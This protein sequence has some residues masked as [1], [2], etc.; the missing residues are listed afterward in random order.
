MGGVNGSIQGVESGE[1]H[2]CCTLRGKLN[3]AGLKI[4]GSLSNATEQYSGSYDWIPSEEVQ[5]IPI[6][7]MMANNDI[8]IEAIPSEYHDTS[9]ATITS[10]D[11][12]LQGYSAWG[13]DELYE[14]T[15]ETK[16]A[17]DMTVSGPTVT[18]PEGYYASAQSKSVASGSATTP[19]TEITAVPT[20][21]V[22][23]S[24]GVV[25][26]SVSTSSGIIPVIEEGY[27]TE[28][29]SGTV[30]VTGSA[31]SQLSTQGAK[32][33]TPTESSQVAV[34]AGKFTTGDVTVSGIPSDYVGS[35]I[36]RRSSSDLTASGDTVT[37]P[38]G[39]YEN[40][41]SK[42]VASAEQ[43]TPTIALNTSTGMVT[44][45]AVQ[46]AGY[47]SSGTKSSTQQLDTQ[48]TIT[49]TPT[50]SQQIAVGAGKYTLG[51]IVVDPIPHNYGL[52]TWD[53]SVLTVS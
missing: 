38:P 25:S 52:I 7:G 42:A 23:A 27:V 37:V 51:A 39:F 5:T 1:M 14:G 18:V 46:S 24:T 21:S 12:M 2:C 6:K 53:G 30:S 36:E 50:Q 8:I 49:I 3:R 28:G 41:S 47:V 45:T 20:I 19:D 48:E 13:A 43:A 22:N 10:G 15:I 40:A 17:E 29:T 35:G 31:T 16:T 44:A 11:Q 26:A 34:S 9:D 32:T 4:S 33:V